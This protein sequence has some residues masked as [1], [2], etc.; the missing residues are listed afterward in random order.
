MQST[1]IFQ[2]N[3]QIKQI[4][5]KKIGIFNIFAVGTR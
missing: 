5:G 3:V 2:L 4:N 1:E